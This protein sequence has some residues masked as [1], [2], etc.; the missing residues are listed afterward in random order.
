MNRKTFLSS[1]LLSAGVIFQIPFSGIFI[2]GQEIRHAFNETVDSELVYDAIICGGSY[3]G[4]SAAMGLGRAL[5]KT[6]VIDSGYPRNRMSP[7]ANN[8][9]SRDG[10]SPE[11]IKNETLHQLQ[12]YKEFLSMKQGEVV[13]I[14]KNESQYRVKLSSGESFSSKFIVIASG[15]VDQLQDIEGLEPLWGRGVYHCPYCH[16]WENRGKKAIV[17]GP[18]TRNL[19]LA[20]MLTNWN[21]NIVY[22]SRGIP[23]ELPEQSIRMLQSMGI[24]FNETPIERISGEPGNIS[25]HF[26][27]GDKQIF[28]TCF[29]P[30]VSSYNS[31]I[32]ETLGCELASNG[33]FVVNEN[34]AT[35]TEGCYAIGDVSNR[36]NGQIIHAAYSGTVVAAQINNQIVR[37]RF[38]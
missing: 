13:E 22:A 36:S 24:S 23:L 5:R 10:S 25:I 26:Q 37:R 20:S 3:A 33:S 8:L 1:S 14:T 12:A 31:K 7:A 27:S 17:I 38:S 2:D 29:A 15:L 30:G 18:G 32:A 4:L 21:P 11:V 34:Y 19:S 28:E 35:S 9:F 6:L 16:G